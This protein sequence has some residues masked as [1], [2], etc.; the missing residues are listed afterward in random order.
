M[1]DQFSYGYLG[2]TLEVKTNTLYY[3]TGAP[4]YDETGRRV[5]GK[6]STAKGEAKGLENLH[7]V[8]YNLTDGKYKVSTCV[9]ECGVVCSFACVSHSILKGSRP[10]F[11][12]KWGTTIVC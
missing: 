11:L 12:S 5:A 9:G 4:I 8:T 2:F 6:N 7:L 10:N 1:F 3:L